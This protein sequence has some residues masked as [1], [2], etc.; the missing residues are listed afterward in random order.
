MVSK[1]DSPLARESTLGFYLNTLLALDVRTGWTSLQAVWGKNQER[2]GGGVHKIRQELPFR[3]RELHTDNGGEFLNKALFRWCQREGVRFTRGR[4]YKKNDQAYVEQKNF[5]VV[6]SP[7]SS[8]R[9]ASGLRSLLHQ[10]GLPAD[11]APVPVGQPIHQL[12]PA[13]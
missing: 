11:A 7:E 1:G 5:A 6:R 4:P 3:L 13:H 8:L 12:F 10:R 9:P 2:V